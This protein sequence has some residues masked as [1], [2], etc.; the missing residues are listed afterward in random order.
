VRSFE[1]PFRALARRKDI[2][3]R[4]LDECRFQQHG[5]RCRARVP[6]E[7]KDPVPIHAP[8]RQSVPCFDAVSLLSGKF[9]HAVSI[10]FNADNF[11]DFLKRLLRRRPRGKRMVAIPDNASYHHA[12]LLEP[13]LRK[14]RER[15][16][17][18]FLPPYSPQL[19]PVERVWKLARRMATHNRYFATLVEVRAAVVACFQ[20]LWNPNPTLRQL[21]AIC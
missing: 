20:R 19:A 16:E 9:A 4:S 21:C 3:L 10:V 6:P 11:L 8:T 2:E 18:L 12:K 14:H 13:W 15:I 7:E 5:T 1:K 17:L